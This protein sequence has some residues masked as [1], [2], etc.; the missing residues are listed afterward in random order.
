M[1]T[2][3]DMALPVTQAAPTVIDRRRD[4]RIDYSNPHLI[5]LLRRP[6][7]VETL[8]P[9]EPEIEPVIVMAPPAST[10]S[11]FPFI[12][13]GSLVFWGVTAVLLWKTMFK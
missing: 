2:V 3:E 4:G 11:A 7:F 12:M 5:D 9:A 6:T 10:M 8:P 1:P 13:M